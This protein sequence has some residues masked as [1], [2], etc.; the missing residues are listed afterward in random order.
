MPIL[1]LPGVPAFTT[2]RLAKRL[3]GIQTANPQVSALAAEFVHFVELTSPLPEAE[4]LV[5]AR[6]LRYGPRTAAGRVGS[7]P[8]SPAAHHRGRVGEAEQSERGG[9]GGWG[10]EGRSEPSQGSHES[11]RLLVVPRIGTIS[12]WSSKATDVAHNCGLDRVRRIERGIWYTVAGPV[13]G[14]RALRAALHDRMTES[15]LASEAEAE[16]LFAHAQPRPLQTID[17]LGEGRVAIETA[18]LSLGLAL[19][20]DEIDYLAESF[21]TLGRNPTDVELMMFAQANSEH[22]RHKIFNADFIL[23]GK[24]QPQSLFQMI[25]RSSEASPTG[26]LSAYKDNAAVME[27]CEANR[28]FPDPD[29][30]VYAFHREPVGI[31]M[32]VETHNHPTAISPHPGAS[33]G[34]GGEIRDEGA[35]GRGSKPKAG[36]TGFTVSNL[37]L[38]GAVQPWEKDFGKPGRIVSALEIMLEG[39]IGGAA[40]NNE[41]GRPNLAG[42]FRTFEMEVPGPAGPEVRGYHK[43]IMIAGG[44]GNIRLPHVHK[45]EVP[46]GAALVVLGGPAMLIGLGGGAASSMASGASEE[47]LDFASVQRD[48]PEMQRRCQEVI[49]RCWALGDANPIYSIHDVGAGGLSNALPELV[50]DSGRGALFE[51]RKIPNDEPGMSPKEI[52]CNEAQER[53]VLA[54]AP[55]GLG[56]FG[57]LCSRERCPFAVLGQATSDGRLVLTDSHFGNRP[58]DMPLALLLGKPPKMLR[59][60]ESARAAGTPFSTGDLD[61]REAILRVLRL[62]AVADKTF[63]ITIGDRTVTGLVC[64]DQMVGPWQV[65]VA[66]AAVT[67]T[68]YD[69]YTGE[70]MAMGERT[71][72]AL[73]DAAASARM[74]VGEALTNIAS[75][76]IAKI[77]DVKLSANWM[78]AAG[79]PGED[80]R[81]YEAVRA[82]GAELAPALGIAIPVGKDS[83]SMSTVWQEAGK[84]KRITAPLSLIVSAF[85]PVS[86]VR[87]SLTPQLRLD[88]GDSELLLVDLGMG[89]HR[90]GGSALAQVYG[91]LGEEAPDLDDPAV[92]KTFFA[93]IQQLNSKGLLLAYHDR[94]DGGLLVTL[95][96]MAFAG[97]C[98]LEVDLA[99]QAC[100]APALLF[101]EEL[102]AVIQVR[103]PDVAVVRAAFAGSAGHIH[104]LGRPVAG[105]RIAFRRGDHT[106]FED[107]RTNLRRV[108]S[109]TTFAMQALRDDPSC[110]NEEHEARGDENDPGMSVR[111]TFD[112]DQDTGAHL[113]NHGARPRVA[114]LREQGVN[115]Q[116]EMAAAF[117]RAGFE[118]VDVHMSD[119]LSG[120]LDLD[121]FRGL[122]ACGGFSYGDVLGAGEGW[123]KSILFHAR[124]RAAFERFFARPDAFTLGVCNGCQAVS[125]LKEIIPGA[126]DWPRFVRNRSEQFEARLALL[127]IEESP[128]VLL[129]GMAG[130]Q[131]P[132]AVAHGEGRAEFESDAQQSAL[133][134]AGLVAARFVNHY[135]GIASRYPDNPNGSPGGMTALTTPDGRVTIL[136]PHPERMFRAVQHSWHPDDWKEDGPWIRLFRNARVFVG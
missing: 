23:D 41:F 75:A 80:A 125:N 120:R 60:A 133:V 6:V 113:S 59:R 129:R 103:K 90:I 135:G 11:S 38:P 56:R 81:L 91:Q 36:L 131:L 4:Q 101:A 122:A 32:K 117:H 83:M 29:T 71:P 99:G 13:R 21:R 79:H 128:S 66:D 50:H 47:D 46:P 43:P 118:A 51:L 124:A 28:F 54:I 110:A 86:D 58:I 123:A 106:L 49:D 45:A 84:Q 87:R 12:P 39:P 94:S 10:A 8:A 96:E 85:A 92:L 53:Y 115:G 37:R 44:F 61:L 67:T 35:V 20:P 73:L 121:S 25:R 9:G 62:P 107:A 24:K 105:S 27:G 97:G 104:S 134:K 77:G 65:P 119:I 112:P 1:S 34:S 19:A 109:E 68:S 3:A 114:I 18:N 95:L 64:R 5:L 126:Q 78:A 116:I 70:A 72:L 130:S 74:A 127:R 14:E 76:P 2:A 30:N 93:T 33:T 88:Q 136:M 63:L 48:N 26:V 89:R 42:Y 52:W 15:V 102:G 57:E 111:L 100:A 82:V 31:L 16:Q 7:P 132:I 69:G 22:C 17:L 40:F 98:G 108:W 55:E